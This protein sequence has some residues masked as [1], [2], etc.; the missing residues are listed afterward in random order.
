MP[1]YTEMQALTKFWHMVKHIVAPVYLM[2]MFFAGART[3][4]L[5]SQLLWSEFVNSTWNDLDET[6]YWVKG[7]HFSAHFFLTV[8]CQALF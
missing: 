3:L 4:T 1:N 6:T 5:L 8:Y 7:E 2:V